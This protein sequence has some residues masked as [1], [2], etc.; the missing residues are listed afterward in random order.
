MSLDASGLAGSGKSVNDA[1]IATFDP[2]ERRQPLLKGR[3]ARLSFRIVLCDHL[4]EAN[5]PHPVDLLRPRRD[6]P[7]RR[8]AEKA[9]E[10]TSPHFRTQGQRPALYRLKRT[11]IGAETGSKT[12]AAVHIQC[13]LWVIMRKA[14]SEQIWSG[15]PQIAAVNADTA[16]S[17]VSAR[18]LNR[19]AIVAGGCPRFC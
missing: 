13:L 17:S 11:L 16:E 9:N 4:D 5:P 10:L 19:F 18:A 14:H 15:L 2:V 8:A 3:N 7:D 12:I 6:R 1:N